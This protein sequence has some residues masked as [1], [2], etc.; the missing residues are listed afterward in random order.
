MQG[1][2]R[3]FKNGVLVVEVPNLITTRGRSIILRY[4]AGNL[5]AWAGG[6][7]LGTGSVAPAAT[8]TKLQFEYTRI[9]V[10]LRAA[11][12]P[13]GTIVVKGSV[14]TRLSG[15]VYELGLYP[16]ARNG[17]TEHSGLMLIDFD[18]DTEVLSGGTKNTTNYRTGTSSYGVAPAASATASVVASQ[19]RSDLSG[20]GNQDSFSLAYFINDAN[21]AS[22]VVRL[23][24]DDAN[25]FQYTVTPGTVTGY[26][27]S[28]WLKSEF[29]A[30]GSPSW[31]GIASAEFIVTAGAAGATA[32]QF[33]GLRI[34]DLDLYPD[35]ALVSRAVLATPIQKFAGEQMDV[36][37]SIGFNI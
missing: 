11:D 34:N 13:A 4:L 2:Y 33:D 29:V 32:V 3:V 16:F 19:I 24:V 15:S 26:R 20:Y 18:A 30:T 14:P 9:G 8:D 10:D 12:V 21:T 37:Y 5:S 27:V 28:D 31:E 7:A 17:S 6:I 23:K 35:Y 36:E 22:I 1:I 25:Y